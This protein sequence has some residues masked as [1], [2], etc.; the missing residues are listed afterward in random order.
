MSV[1]RRKV[2]AYLG[3]SWG[4]GLMAGFDKLL[5]EGRNP[6]SRTI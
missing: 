6:V 3:R 4:G 1:L 2:E 5:I